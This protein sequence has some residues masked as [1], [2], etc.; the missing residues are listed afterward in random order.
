MDMVMPTF[1]CSNLEFFNGYPAVGWEVLKHR[2]KPLKTAIPVT[3][4]KHQRYE[5]EDAHELPSHSQKLKF[6]TRT[7]IHVPDTLRLQ[8]HCLKSLD[9]ERCKRFMS[10][11]LVGSYNRLRTLVI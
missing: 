1:L 6:T 10:R 3:N 5:V 8:V 7:C 4:E 2:Y 11:T 9:Q